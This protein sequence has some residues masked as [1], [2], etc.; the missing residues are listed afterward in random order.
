MLSRQEARTRALLQIAA[1]RIEL[2]PEDEV[3]IVDDATIERPWGWVFFYTS[4][5]WLETQNFSYALAGNAPLL[6][7]GRTGASH[8]LGT[9]RPVEIYLLAFEESGDPH[10]VR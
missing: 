2:P 9:A 7:D 5:L 8:F 3:V 10:A 6:I 4:K 1:T